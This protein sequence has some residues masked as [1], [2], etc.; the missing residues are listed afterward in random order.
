[1]KTSTK[2]GTAV[3]V[4]GGGIQG[5][6]TRKHGARGGCEPWSAQSRP[7]TPSCTSLG[8]AVPSAQATHGGA[9]PR[10][11]SGQGGVPPERSHGGG[12]RQGIAQGGVA[13]RCR[14]QIRFGCGPI[15][16][17]A[18][19]VGGRGRAGKAPRRRAR[20]TGGRGGG[21]LP[22]P[23]PGNAHHNTAFNPLSVHSAS[24]ACRKTAHQPV[25]TTSTATAHDTWST[26][27]G[28]L[29]LDA[30]AKHVL[31]RAFHNTCPGQRSTTVRTHTHAH[32]R[33]VHDCM[34]W[35]WERAVGWTTGW[36]ASILVLLKERPWLRAAGWGPTVAGRHENGARA[37][38]P[39]AYRGACRAA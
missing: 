26:H 34:A 30:D 17:A 7:P 14:T 15:S 21:T 28:G 27:G 29:G 19:R 37:S 25:E 33:C 2:H 22:A 1:V 4:T 39:A 6:S 32:A 8:W 11:H 10:T 24:R 16:A 3:A 5:E 18:P 13:P 35:E 23:R 36:V 31:V 20:G 38:H 9:T 12:Q